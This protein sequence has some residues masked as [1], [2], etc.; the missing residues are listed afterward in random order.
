MQIL[1]ENVVCDKNT[2]FVKLSS[3]R[4]SEAVD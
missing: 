3:M 4:F 2:I 1:T